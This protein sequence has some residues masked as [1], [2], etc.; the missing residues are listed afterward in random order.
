L[1]NKKLAIEEA[2]LARSKNKVGQPT[3]T[4]RQVIKAYCEDMDIL[5]D[6]LIEAMDWDCWPLS[7][8]DGD[9]NK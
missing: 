2:W 8:E 7:K 9:D 6:H 4:P 3:R 5:T 1:D